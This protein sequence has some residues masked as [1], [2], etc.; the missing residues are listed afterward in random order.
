MGM[1]GNRRVEPQAGI[2]PRREG[3]PTTI[4]DRLRLEAQAIAALSPLTPHVVS[5]LDFGRT[6]AGRPYIVM[7]RLEGRSL[8]EELAERGA[9][10]LRGRRLAGRWALGGR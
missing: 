4:V 10:G 3:Y 1:E 7:E 9:G 2:R 8:K 6:P 5:V